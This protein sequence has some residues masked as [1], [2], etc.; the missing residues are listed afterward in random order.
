MP[1]KDTKP[2]PLEVDPEHIHTVNDLMGPHGRLITKPATRDQAPTHPAQTRVTVRQ[3]PA[4]M[5]PFGR[6]LT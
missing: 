4:L 5:G 6:P 2:L 1:N 3:T